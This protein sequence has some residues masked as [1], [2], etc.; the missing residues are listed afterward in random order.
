MT[1]WSM[2]QRPR[3]LIQDKVVEFSI[4]CVCCKWT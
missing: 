3:E 2:Q 4:F 1:K